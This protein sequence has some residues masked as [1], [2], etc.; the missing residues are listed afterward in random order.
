MT[1][2]AELDSAARPW[3]ADT[4]GEGVSHVIN[5][6]TEE[7]IAAYRNATEADVDAAVGRAAAAARAWGRTPPVQR[8]ELLLKI[9]DAIEAEAEEFA[10]LE[11]ENVGK[12]IAFARDE[13]TWVY[14]VIRFSAGAARVSHA[15]AAGEYAN[16]STSWLRREPLG[17]VGLITPWNYP[18]LMA[19]WK[20]APAVAAGNAV[21]IKPSELTP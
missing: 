13:M 12:P 5:P 4:D 16:G 11:C 18:M 9:A 6:A 1:A 3:L 2:Y 17:V 7:E 14:D 19:T 15:P 8:A 21:V 10:R 20:L